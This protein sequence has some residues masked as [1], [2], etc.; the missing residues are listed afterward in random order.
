MSPEKSVELVK[1]NAY[2]AS[3][4]GAELI[5]FSEV[6]KDGFPADKIIK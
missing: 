4:Y 6:F 1:E 3:K 2:K 5:V